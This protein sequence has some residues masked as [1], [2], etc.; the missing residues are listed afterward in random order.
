MVQNVRIFKKSE[1]KKT[2]KSK[3]NDFKGV[4][5]DV[6]YWASVSDKDKHGEWISANIMVRM[7]KKAAEYFEEVS[8]TTKN[9]N[10]TT[11]YARVQDSW[12]KAVPGKEHNNIVLFVNDFDAI[13]GDETETD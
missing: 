9:P 11:V 5:T 1:T 13:D 10:V 12:L 3:D 2:K 6:Y 7:S 8:E 4:K